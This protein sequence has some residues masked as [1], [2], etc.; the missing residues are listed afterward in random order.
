VKKK[1][2]ISYSRADSAIVFPFVEKLQKAVGD[3]FWMD[4]N[5][6]ESGDQF[7]HQIINA[8]NQADIVLFMHSESSLASEWVEK[9]IQ[10][11]QGKKK[12]IVPILVD[13]KPLDGW[14]LFQFGGNDFIDPTNEIHCKK[15]IENLK[16]WLKI[17]NNKPLTGDPF[18]DY[19]ASEAETAEFV[20]DLEEAHFLDNVNPL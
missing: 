15:L 13:G 8:I 17:E 9:E 18:I 2:F 10:Y 20:K 12:K 4:L 19:A 5:G 7:I 11:A 1:V 3:V 6:I 16:L 14:F